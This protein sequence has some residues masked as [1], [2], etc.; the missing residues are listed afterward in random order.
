[1]RLIAAQPPS[2]AKAAK[3]KRKPK[4]GLII[5]IVAVV[6]LLLVAAVAAVLWTQEGE[7]VVAGHIWKRSIDIK[8]YAAKR[9]GSWYNSRPSR[10]YNVRTEQR[11]RSTRSVPD[12]ESCSQVKRDQG[13]ETY[14]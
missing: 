12:G 11:Q 1:M 8:R 9:D 3:R 5:G 2:R 6:V 4:R 14:T 13:D 10:A 7:F